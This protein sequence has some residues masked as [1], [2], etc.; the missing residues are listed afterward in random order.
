[1]KYNSSGVIFDL[2]FIRGM[3]DGQCD[4]FHFLF[5]GS[6]KPVDVC[7]ILCIMCL[8]ASSF[9]VHSFMNLKCTLSFI[10]ILCSMCL[11]MHGQRINRWWGLFSRGVQD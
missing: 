11:K 9:D 7:F 10:N 6:G 4:S 3:A 2:A 1:L 5:F 8:L